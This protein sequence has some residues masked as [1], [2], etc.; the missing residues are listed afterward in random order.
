MMIIPVLYVLRERRGDLNAS[1][2]A[3]LDGL[4]NL[5]GRIGVFHDAAHIDLDSHA[6]LAKPPIAPESPN[7]ASIDPERRRLILILLSAE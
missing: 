5:G 2:Q 6:T 4:L 7:S 1:S 3:L